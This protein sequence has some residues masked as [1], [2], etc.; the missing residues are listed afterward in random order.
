MEA[1]REGSERHARL[2]GDGVNGLFRAIECCHDDIHPSAIA[3]PFKLRCQ[4][5]FDANTIRDRP[6]H[7]DEDVDIAAACGII[8]SGAKKPYC[9]VAAQSFSDFLLD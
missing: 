3:L 8:H 2:P 7:I 4:C 6:R 5:R 1:V 9:H